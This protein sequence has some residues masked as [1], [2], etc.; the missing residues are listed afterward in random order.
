[1][2]YSDLLN[3]ARTNLNTHGL[4][5]NEIK[6]GN[7]SQTGV[8][9]LGFF[10]RR[11]ANK[12]NCQAISEKFITDFKNEY[13]EAVAN[14]AMTRLGFNESKPLM[15]SM[16]RNLDVEANKLLK[17]ES[18]QKD[19]N[20]CAENIFNDIFNKDPN[21]AKDFG[22]LI[23]PEAGKA[24]GRFI[25]SNMLTNIE[26]NKDKYLDEAK[27]QLT[28]IYKNISDG[29]LTTDDCV[30]LYR[31]FKGKSNVV[32]VFCKLSK[33]NGLSDVK[34]FIEAKGK[35]HKADVEGIEI[36]NAFGRVLKDSDTRK[37]LGLRLNARYHT[38]WTNRECLF[39][40]RCGGNNLVLENG[41]TFATYVAKMKTCLRF[42]DTHIKN[43]TPL[44][45]V[46]NADL[47]VKEKNPLLKNDAEEET[48]KM[49]RKQALEYMKMLPKDRDIEETNL[50]GKAYTFV[51][52]INF[53]KTDSDALD[54]LHVLQTVMA[55]QKHANEPID[56]LQKKAHALEKNIALTMGAYDVYNPSKFPKQFRIDF[57]SDT[58]KLDGL[59]LLIEERVSNLN[60]MECLATTLE[61]IK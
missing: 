24:F 31:V 25:A 7:I 52:A 57:D 1:M 22:G 61:K 40:N 32:D 39:F 14:K 3:I 27:E 5:F 36:K 21:V 28:K 4:S 43:E 51:S 48:K 15:L 13:G 50:K 19:I 38:S 59:N 44:E 53:L 23:D 37:E 45:Y 55:Y 8:S 29:A 6:D 9:N 56:V 41:K 58:A 12:A 34:K 47:F 42:L 20:T 46:V 26:A 18:I 54:K 17:L 33:S 10:G 49:L 30:R 60:A 16:V 11:F 35:F 2:P